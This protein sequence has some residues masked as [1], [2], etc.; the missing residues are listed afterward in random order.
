[1][2]ELNIINNNFVYYIKVEP[3]TPV[4]VGG[5][6]EKNYKFEID[7]VDLDN[8]VY[9]IDHEKLSKELLKNKQLY[10]AYIQ[11]ALNNNLLDFFKNNKINAQDFSRKVYST[12]GE[13]SEIKA[14]I[15]DGFGLPYIPGSSLKGAIRSAFLHY[16]TEN[17]GYTF[18][19]DIT[20]NNELLEKIF[21]SIDNNRMKFLQVSDIYFN[22]TDLINTKVFT[23]KKFS[24][25]FN[26][27]WKD[28]LKNGYNEKFSKTGFTTLY[29]VFLPKN[30]SSPSFGIGTLSFTEKIIDFIKKNKKNEIEKDPNI[31]NTNKTPNQESLKVFISSINEYTKTHVLREIKFFEKYQ[32]DKTNIILEKLNN[33]LK[34]IPSDSTSYCILRLGGGSGFHAIT[35]DWQFD[36]HEI[37]SFDEKT[38]R[39]KYANKFSAKTRK[40]AF[41]YKNN[42]SDFY[43]FGFVKI[44]FIE[45][46]EYEKLRKTLK[47]FYESKD[48][49]SDTT[50]T[51]HQ[52]Q[53]KE[54]NKVIEPPKPF[55]GTLKQGIDKIPAEV[56][57]SGTPNIVRLLIE[58]MNI[59]LPL[60]SYRSPLNQKYIY[61]K[62]TEF[63]K[64]QIKK[65]SYSGQIK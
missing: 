38:H 49:V 36:T 53:V 1:M 6:T 31:D 7:A 39:G 40:I 43:P 11:A 20:N 24:N 2:N 45:K 47:E 56:I 52:E 3:L 9:I 26:G 16:K 63:S 35:G 41:I 25:K 13:S 64:G 44:S 22:D 30:N 37:N 50:I 10:D 51:T 27:G 59:E 29:E 61:V 28:S 32:N 62:I 12:T 65:I 46:E 57:D 34:Q 15:R 19:D 17:N 8:Q 5:A 4:Y 23:L 54:E 18:N 14:F 58:N 42:V 55:E 33:I 60:N 21:G 48:K